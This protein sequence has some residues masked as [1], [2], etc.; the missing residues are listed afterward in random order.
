M[1]GA[2]EALAALQIFCDAAKRETATVEMTRQVVKFLY[3]AQ[4][5]PE[6]RF[7][8]VST[9][10]PNGRTQRLA[11]PTQRLI[12]HTQRRIASSQS[13]IARTQS[14]IAGHNGAM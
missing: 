6:M 2:R 9:R 8:R 12:G 11:G 10:R 14:E 4:H 13:Q 3:R 1:S 5:D 7:E